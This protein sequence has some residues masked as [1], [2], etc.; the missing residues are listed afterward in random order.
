MSPTNSCKKVHLQNRRGA[1]YGI[2]EW[3]D[4]ER[5][6]SD[7]Q[8]EFIV[9]KHRNGG[10]DNIRLKFQAHLGKFE[11][12]SEFDSSS[13]YQSKIN[14]ENNS[15]SDKNIP[16]A[17]EAFGESYDNISDEDTPF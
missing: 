10:L 14:S 17:N 1:Y 2:D 11:N 4:E 16:N 15:F 8:A 3:D 13:E 5:S 6:P 9:S 7:G 12:L